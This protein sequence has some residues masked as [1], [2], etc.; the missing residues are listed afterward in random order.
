V[1]ENSEVMAAVIGSQ[2]AAFNVPAEIAYFNTASLAPQL[3]AVRAAGLAALERRGRP[4]MISASDW[5]VDAERLRSLFAA[6]IGATADGVALVP[7]SSYGLAVAARNLPLRAGERVLV[8]A[9]EYPSGIYTWRAAAG[10][11]GAEVLTVVRERAQS[12]TAAVLP[13]LDE[14]VAIVSVPNVHWT[15]GALLDLVAIAQRTREVGARLVIDGSQSV[16]AVPLDMRELRPDFLVTVGYKWLL[17]PLSVGYLYVAEEHRDG[18]PLEENWINRA[19]S[20]DFAALVDYSDDYQPGARRFD[21]GQRTK[22]ELV[23]MAITALE[24]IL[25]WQVPRIAAAL[26]SRTSDIAQQVSRLGLEVSTPDAERGP[27]ML[28]VRLPDSARPKIPAALAHANCFAALRGSA[29]RISPHLHTTDEDVRRLLSG[30]AHAIE[31]TSRGPLVS[32]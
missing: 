7:A 31:P 12:W 32:R 3:H 2:R 22:F 23:P 19:G 10:R 25:A 1:S 24:Q 30:L 29:L 4:W 16:G 13:A 11:S 17:G 27:H 26:A 5:F 8:L 20:E 18:E 21:S 6:I 28:G 9:E 15:D 14:R